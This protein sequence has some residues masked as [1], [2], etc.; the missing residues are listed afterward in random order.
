MC[1]N[2]AQVTHFGP[3]GVYK[4]HVLEDDDSTTKLYKAKKELKYME[5]RCFLDN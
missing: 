1:S 3:T 2:A 5:I 4:G